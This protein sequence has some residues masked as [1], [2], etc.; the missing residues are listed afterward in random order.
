M[1]APSSSRCVAKACRNAS[2]HC[3]SIDRARLLPPSSVL[4]SG[5][6]YR[7]HRPADRAHGYR[8]ARGRNARRHSRMD[9]RRRVLRRPARREP[10]APVA[11][12][13]RGVAR[14]RR[15]AP[16]VGGP[17]GVTI[18]VGHRNVGGT[19]REPERG[20]VA[21]AP[22]GDPVRRGRGVGPAAAADRSAMPGAAHTTPRR[23]YP[24]GKRILARGRRP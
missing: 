10:P 17:H 19:N 6:G 7:P 12:G 22:V 18:A 9:A 11:R 5:R 15:P 21:F 16:L 23:G 4:F 14:P 20:S 13:A 1:S 2:S 3:S 24:P 8:A